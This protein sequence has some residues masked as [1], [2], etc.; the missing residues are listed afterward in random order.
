MLGNY[1]AIDTL[2][3]SECSDMMQRD[4]SLLSLA[5]GET[6]QVFE[7]MN[8]I[9]LGKLR[10]ELHEFLSKEIEEKYI[11]L[12]NCNG[13]N[14]SVRDS[15]ESFTVK[16]LEG[17]SALQLTTETFAFKSHLTMAILCEEIPRRGFLGNTTK[18][19]DVLDRAKDFEQHLPASI[20]MGIV[21]FFFVCSEN[22]LPILLEKAKREMG[23]VQNQIQ[24]QV[25][26]ATR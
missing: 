4:I 15:M 13:R 23:K 5:T 8:L 14:Y 10:I 6:E 16:Q 22:L 24:S 19:L 25:S 7:E 12:F 20:G 21:N 1:G 11:P 18:C 17:I 2:L 3:R 9:E 26:E